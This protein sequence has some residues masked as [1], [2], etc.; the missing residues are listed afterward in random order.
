MGITVK[1]TTGPLM[2]GQTFS[3]HTLGTKQIAH[4]FIVD[5]N[6]RKCDFKLRF[7]TCLEYVG[8]ICKQIVA[9]LWH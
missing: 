6:H 7:W 4:D 3:V 5:L 2:N 9:Q 8:Y 1:S